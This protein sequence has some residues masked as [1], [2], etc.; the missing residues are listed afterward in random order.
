M[1]KTICTAAIVL[2]IG[3]P[4]AADTLEPPETIVETAL[5]APL[6]SVGTTELIITVLAALL[7]WAAVE[8]N[9][10]SK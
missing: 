7:V 4:A 10:R 1:R 3:L 6:A 2:C 8:Q 9:N 5:P